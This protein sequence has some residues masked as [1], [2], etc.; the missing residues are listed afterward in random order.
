MGEL[1]LH[2]MVH[3]PTRNSNTLDL[4]FT[5]APNL[6]NRVSSAQGLSDH[7]TVIVG[8]QLKASINKKEPHSVPLYHKANWEE[9]KQRLRVLATSYF[10]ASKDVVR[11]FNTNWSGIKRCITTCIA[12]LIP[13]KSIGDRLHLPY[14]TKPI[15][16]KKSEK[17]ENLSESEEIQP[18]DW[19]QYHTL[20]KEMKKEL[21][22]AS[23]DYVINMLN[24]KGD[25]PSAMKWLFR[26]IK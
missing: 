6:I 19:D 14:I 23:S 4:F 8:H 11:P 18:T 3:I 20:K 1:N 12:D 22:A 2:Q 21:N 9:V 26:F 5:D 17:A 16:R 13:H 24:V 7:D 25:A 10:A 15:Q